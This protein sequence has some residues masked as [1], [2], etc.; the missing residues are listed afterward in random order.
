EH[1]IIVVS[2]LDG[3]TDA[4]IEASH[5]AQL[6]NRR[7]YRRIVA[8]IRTRHLALVEQLPLKDD[9][10]NALK[11]DIDRLLFDMLDVCQTLSEPTSVNLP[12]AEYVDAIIG[13]GERLSARIIA[14]LLRHNNIKGVALDAFDLIITDDVFGNANADIERTRE[15][16]QS[17]LMPLLERKLVPVITGFIGST[18][19]GKPTTLGR[20]GSDFTASLLAVC[21]GASEVWIWA[22]VDGMMSADPRELDNAHAIDELSYAEVAELTY[23]GARILHTRMVAPLKAQHI[24]LFVKN[25]FKP[26]YVGTRIHANAPDFPPQIK[27]ITSS[28]SIGLVTVQHADLGD[29]VHTI[30]ESLYQ[31]IG[32]KP[33]VLMTAQSPN[34]RFLCFIIPTSAGPDAL[35]HITLD[36]EK[37]LGASNGQWSLT[38]VTIITAIGTRLN[39]SPRLLGDILVALDDIPT[40]AI[41]QGASHCSLSVVVAPHDT[42]RALHRIHTII[43]KQKSAMPQ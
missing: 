13:V 14:T 8:T 15:R 35:R 1:L 36:L 20:G 22:D 16:I 23:F 33:D 7:G 10:R 28:Q 30:N 40:L 4:L 18:L 42:D 11:A 2:A 9:E 26:Q 41:S 27:A 39:D 25:V 24:P 34:A 37:R 43:H 12:V 31:T 6:G 3:V 5:L 38:P 32:V 19:S 17:N 29:L 21:T